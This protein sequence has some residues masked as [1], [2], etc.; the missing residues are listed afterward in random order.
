MDIDTA[1]GY[2]MC[3][4]VLKAREIL[5]SN[6]ISSWPHMK[7]DKD[8]KTKHRELVKRADLESR[9]VVSTASDLKRILGN[10]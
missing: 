2:F 9:N 4:D 10:G 5:D 3:L 7:N 1:T 8:R 6:V